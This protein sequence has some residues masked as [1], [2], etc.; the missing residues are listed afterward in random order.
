MKPSTIALL[1]GLTLIGL[2]YRSRAATSP[3]RPTGGSFINTVKQAISE[4][5]PKYHIP[6]SLLFGI[7]MAESSCNPEL[8]NRKHHLTGSSF[9][10]YGLT[11]IACKD[12]GVDYNRL[13]TLTGTEGVRAQTETAAKYLSKIRYTY[14]GRFGIND[15]EAAVQAYNVGIGAYKKGKRNKSYLYTVLKYAR[16][17]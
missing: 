6:P 13:K 5:A 2:S 15:W 8:L 12:V 7:C 4:I 3:S 9:G 14:N 1:A 10:L 17:Y 11:K 16:S